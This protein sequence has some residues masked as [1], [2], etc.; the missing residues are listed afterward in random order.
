MVQVFKTRKEKIKPRRRAE[1]IT[2]K[3]RVNDMEFVHVLKAVEFMNEYAPK[4]ALYRITLFGYEP[5][6]K[7]RLV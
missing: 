4:S 1:L 6:K 2:Y 5:I 3:Y 7:T